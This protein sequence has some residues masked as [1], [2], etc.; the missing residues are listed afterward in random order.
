MFLWKP[1][2]S[3]PYKSELMSFFTKIVHNPCKKGFG[4]WF[5]NSLVKPH[6]ATH[7]C[8]CA[9]KNY[10]WWELEPLISIQTKMTSV[11]SLT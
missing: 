6:K 1:K 9:C 7:H 2:L 10:D 3:T 11:L 8:K 5:N 4:G